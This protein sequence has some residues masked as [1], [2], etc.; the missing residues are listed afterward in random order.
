MV[1]S[2]FYVDGETYDTAVAESNDHPGATSPSQAPSGFYPA[3]TVYNEADPDAAANSAAEAA[4]SAAASATSAAT[5]AAVVAAAVTGAAGTTTPLVD[6][7]AAVG[8]S[9]KWAREDHVHPTDTTRAGKTTNTFTGK[10]TFNAATASNMTGAVAMTVNNHTL[11][12]SGGPF[13]ANYYQITD[14]YVGGVNDTI[15][16]WN[17]AYTWGAGCQGNAHVMFNTAG[18]FAAPD[19]GGTSAPYYFIH[20]DTMTVSASNGG[21]GTGVGTSRGGFSVA[22]P[23]VKATA[24]ATNLFALNNT[25]YNISLGAG[26]S[27]YYKSILQLVSLDT[28]VVQGSG[29]DASLIFSAMPGAV[30]WRQ[31]IDINAANGAVPYNS[32]STI[33]RVTGGGTADLG[34]D[35]TGVTF[36]T[37]AAKLNGKVGIGAQNPG[38]FLD[39]NPNANSASAPAPATGSVVRFVGADGS[40]NVMSFDTFAAAPQFVFRRANTSAAA[41][42][43]VASA[44]NLFVIGGMG[45]DGSGAYSATS[46]AVLR[47]VAEEAWVDA[48]HHG[49]RVEVRTTPKASAT[50]ATAA[51]FWGSGGLSVGSTTDPGFGGLALHPAASV[52]PANNGDFVIEATSN[53]SL[54][55]RYKGSDGVVRSASLTLT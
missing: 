34:L 33:M 28:D 11:S 37:A 25:E 38:A 51:T 13:S 10:Q 2:S 5:S 55:L 49:A 31:L 20:A 6:G 12:G 24:G 45:W 22:N 1:D 32:S 7:T 18:N 39:V 30:G 36:N 44:D 4:S 9:P 35:F 26:S 54:T 40:N 42:S 48:T 50:A 53:T 15:L 16:G 17:Y 46:Q 3:G 43:Q 14:T 47:A 52:T 29:Y 41:R 19:S 21:T 8:S 27:A 23:V